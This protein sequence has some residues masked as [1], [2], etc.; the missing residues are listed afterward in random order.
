MTNP[1]LNTLNIHI[2][3]VSNG[4]TDAH[5]QD[6]M[7]LPECQGKGIGSELM[8]RMIEYLK[9]NKIYMISVIFDEELKSFYEKFGFYI[10]L[11]GQMETYEAD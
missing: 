2:D 5:I 7:V 11:S 9:L 6:L 4:V 1:F 8:N 3:C 10:M